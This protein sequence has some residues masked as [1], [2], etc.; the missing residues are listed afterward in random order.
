MSQS[1]EPAGRP[2]SARFM[3]ARSPSAARPA[4]KVATAP[5]EDRPGPGYERVAAQRAVADDHRPAEPHPART[6]RSCRVTRVAQRLRGYASAPH[7][8]RPRGVRQDPMRVRLRPSGAQYITRRRP[9][10]PSASLVTANDLPEV[11]RRV[12]S[13]AGQMRQVRLTRRSTASG[14]TPTSGPTR[15]VAPSMS[16][17]VVGANRRPLLDACAASSRPARKSPGSSARVTACAQLP[18]RRSPD[19]PGRPKRVPIADRGVETARV[20]HL[21]TSSRRCTA[22]KIISASAIQT[23]GFPGRSRPR[24]RHRRVASTGVERCEENARNTMAMPTAP[25]ASGSPSTSDHAHVSGIS[26][27]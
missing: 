10:A 19:A 26:Q 8:R 25:G 13:T 17:R 1:L 15:L 11:G 21:D 2:P 4:E 16:R 18:R 3:P 27:S 22:R 9:A 24:S 23:N 5:P 14:F 20:A 12:P 6:S 7:R